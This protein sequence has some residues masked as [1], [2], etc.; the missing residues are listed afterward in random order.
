MSD[1]VTIS[2]SALFEILPGLPGVGPIPEA[3]SATGQGT[4]SEGFVVHFHPRTSESW[5][6]NFQGG[7]G[8]L[9]GVFLY[10]DKRTVIVVSRGQAYH[11]DP[12][13]RSL[14][15]HFGGCITTMVKDD[16]RSLL[17]FADWTHLWAFDTTGQRWESERVSID[18]IRNLRIEADSIVGEDFDPTGEKWRKF[19]VSLETG[20]LKNR[21][22]NFFTRW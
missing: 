4:Q 21:L 2:D 10:P 9:D 3:F 16:A 17:I 8:S 20:K 13:S 22:L 7:D 15:R 1:A 14:L 11:V 19:S 5:I 6:G 12:Q 18:G